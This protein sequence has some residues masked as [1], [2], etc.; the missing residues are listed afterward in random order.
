LNTDTTATPAPT[1][2]TE[3]SAASRA[4][5]PAEARGAAVPPGPR[6]SRPHAR[7]APAPPATRGFRSGSR[8]VHGKA[9][10]PGGERAAE[11]PLRP[12]PLPVNG[13]GPRRPADFTESEY[14]ATHGH[15]IMAA[16][17]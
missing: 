4:A 9:P 7:A 12:P 1:E 15:A 13:P 6:R 3:D 16:C 2:S 10:A 17:Q 11:R 8:I 14:M 5:H